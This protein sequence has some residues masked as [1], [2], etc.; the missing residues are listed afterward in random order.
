M[1]TVPSYGSWKDSYLF[2][3]LSNW[4]LVLIE[5]CIIWGTSD[6]GTDN[7]MNLAYIYMTDQQ[8]LK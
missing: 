7:G 2:S 4:T 6:A 5:W 8:E 3:V 1:A